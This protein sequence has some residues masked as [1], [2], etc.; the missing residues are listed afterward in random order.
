MQQCVHTQTSCVNS[1]ITVRKNRP[2]ATWRRRRK[3]KPAW[4]RWMHSQ[5]APRW[6]R[7]C[8]L[9][10]L[11]F[12]R[13]RLPRLRSRGRS[14]ATAGTRALAPQ[15]L[16]RI[17]RRRLKCP[18]GRCLSTRPRFRGGTPPPPPGDSEMPRRAGSTGT[19]LLAAST[20]AP[21]LAG[22]ETPLLAGSATPLLGGSTAV[23]H[24]ADSEMPRQAGSET[25]PLGGSTGWARLRGAIAGTRPP[26]LAGWMME[27]RLPEEAA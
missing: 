17:R 7:T 1:S 15:R 5:R 13:P 24:L 3:R 21:L 25:P 12:L 16:R 9:H 10:Q 8:P 19:P 20:A 26:L 14:V 4:H 22:L 11:W 6:G 27:G 2:C 18:S 23:P